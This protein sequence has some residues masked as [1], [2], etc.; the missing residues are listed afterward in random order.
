[1]LFESLEALS[2]CGNNLLGLGASFV[3]WC[4]IY[5]H[6]LGIVNKKDHY[7]TVSVKS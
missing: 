6:S 3:R 4:A 5:I 1:M 2:G 7:Y